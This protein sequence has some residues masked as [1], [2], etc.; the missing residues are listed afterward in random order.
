LEEK[1]GEVPGFPMEGWASL[2]KEKTNMDTNTAT[3]IRREIMNKGEV[4]K[5][6]ET[7]VQ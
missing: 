2:L 1:A 7:L 4:I 5:D 6:L 3:R